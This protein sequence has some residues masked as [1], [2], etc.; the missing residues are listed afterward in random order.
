MTEIGV[1]F[2]FGGYPAGLT[3]FVEETIISSL[4][5]LATRWNTNCL[6]MQ[7]FTSGF[8]GLCHCRMFDAS[9]FLL[10][11][12]ALTIL[13]V[14]WFRMNYKIVLFISIKRFIGILMRIT[15]NM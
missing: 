2:F 1:P 12:K 5:I 3:P 7:G 15:L 4:C 14:F 9:S 13:G 11:K 8:S 6:Y 10:P